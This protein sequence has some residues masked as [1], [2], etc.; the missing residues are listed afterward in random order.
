MIC[1]VRSK[2]MRKL[3]SEILVFCVVIFGCANV[4]AQT[5]Y[6]RGKNAYENLTP[7]QQREAR[8]QLF[9]GEVPL[10]GH[11]AMAA[12]GTGAES[13]LFLKGLICSEWMDTETIVRT[14]WI[15]QYF[16]ATKGRNS[17]PINS[18]HEASLQDVNNYCKDNKIAPV[19][20]A[21]AA[22]FR[23]A[24]TRLIVRQEE[25]RKR[26]EEDRRGREAEEI[27]ARGVDD[28]KHNSSNNP[29]INSNK[30]SMS[31]EEWKKNTERVRMQWLR[32]Y[33][34][35]IN[36]SVDQEVNS[37]QGQRIYRFCTNNPSLAAA[38]AHDMIIGSTLVFATA[39]I[40]STSLESSN[41]A[42]VSK[43]SW[44]SKVQSEKAK[45]VDVRLNGVD[46]KDSMPYVHIQSGFNSLSYTC[47]WANGQ[48]RQ[49]SL[50]FIAMPNAEYSLIA[51]SHQN[52]VFLSN[53][54]M[55]I[56]ESY[57]NDLTRYSDQACSAILFE[58]VGHLYVSRKQRS[59]SCLRE[60][61]ASLGLLF[62]DDNQIVMD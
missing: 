19:E 10:P 56:G 48:S 41:K 37:A 46:H 18:N 12:T 13:L 47:V 40:A 3:N 57:L 36:L 25:S 58:C 31:C 1:F 39:N 52:G 60:K 16:D 2:E 30:I 33:L 62:N 51:A 23:K 43:L 42:N 34:A 7:S 15:N 59:L 22:A 27:K 61:P 9:R 26:G 11:K 5:F 55:N 24:E 54:K 8:D 45:I 20:H 49:N 14:S 50:D 4:N 38:K 32:Q 35:A 44:R 21:F 28:A 29:I 53:A 17:L 6:E